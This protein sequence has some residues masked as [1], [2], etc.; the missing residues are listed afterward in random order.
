MRYKDFI[1]LEW[2]S[3]KRSPNFSKKFIFKIL[4][5]IG[6]F[7]MFLYLIALS[8]IAFYALRDKFPSLDA[9]QKGSHYFY[10][11]FGLVFMAQL[12]V[13][14]ASFKVRYFMLLPI[15]KHKIVNY[16][17]FKIVLHPVNIAFILMIVTYSGILLFNHYDVL[18]VVAWAISMMA[19]VVV[20]NFL[21]LFAEKIPY[22][23]SFMSLLLIVFFLKIHF[24]TEHLSP[25]GMLFYQI[26]KQPML[27][28]MPLLALALTYFVVFAYIF[29]RFYLDAGITKTRMKNRTIAQLSWLNNFGL[30]GHF[31]KNDLKLIWR[32][33]RPKQGL[34]SVIVFLFIGALVISDYNGKL[35]QAY[36]YKIMFSIFVT[37]SF[38][39]QF[40][41][42]IPAW[43]SAYYPMLMSQNLKYR[44]YLE[45]K[46]WIMA[47]SV[48]VLL[49]LSLPYLYFGW[50]VYSLVLVTA[51]FNI[52][53]NIPLTMISGMFRT[54]PI[55]LD[56]KVKAFQNNQPFDIKLMIY[57][58]LRLV[59]PIVIFIL[60]EK[61]LGYQYGLAFFLILGVL[62]IVFRDWFLDKL[63]RYY[64]Q[65]KYITLAGFRKNQA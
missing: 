14:S 49:M 57:N 6:Y 36:F 27:F 22:L 58:I 47:L 16:Y 48:L 35:H 30:M 3:F 7:F 20:I 52:G 37:G 43:D 12:Y 5:G 26:Y 64:I 65:R 41:N 62:G 50:R 33:E 17:L 56:K 61:Y 11:F 9:F 32:N 45:A 59:L 42:F 28:V 15:K 19:A 44:Q 51:I 23:R 46:W 38:I 25:I 34:I 40:G 55:D 53:V 63:V 10:V 29:R 54:Q 31:I 1:K 13:S 2:K 18:G 8:F 4:A 60:L 39:A 24:F 21:F